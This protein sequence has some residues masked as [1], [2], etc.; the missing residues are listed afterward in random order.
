[1]LFKGG[2]AEGPLVRDVLA[3]GETGELLVLEAPRLQTRHTHGTGC[4][5]AS[6]IASGLACGLP[7]AEAVRK[8]HA[9]VHE[10]IRTAPGL[11]S[12][13]G[14]LNHFVSP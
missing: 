5:L 8:A 13:H 7:L 1:V 12:G 10:A 6:A 9:Y 4:T 2:H 14:P 11:G 3:D